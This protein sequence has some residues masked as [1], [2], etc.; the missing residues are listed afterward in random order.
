MHPGPNYALWSRS[1]DCDFCAMRLTHR[2]QGA[3]HVYSW[4]SIGLQ[5]CYSAFHNQI[6]RQARKL[7]FPLPLSGGGLVT[8]HNSKTEIYDHYDPPLNRVASSHGA[9]SEPIGIELPPLAAPAA[10]SQ[11]PATGAKGLNADEKPSASVADTESSPGP[12]RKVSR[13]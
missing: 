13:L 4:Y 2:A 3:I 10:N 11:S 8:M 12:A 5:L 9:A 7:P 1:Q 6:S